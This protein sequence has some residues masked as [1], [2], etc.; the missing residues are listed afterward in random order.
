MNVKLLLIK[1][2]T[3]VNKS[4]GHKLDFLCIQIIRNEQF[5]KHF[6]EQRN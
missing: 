3:Y 5:I 1:E 2:L 6:I 4:C